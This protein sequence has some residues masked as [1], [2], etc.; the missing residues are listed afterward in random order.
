MGFPDFD[1]TDNFSELQALSFRPR[2]SLTGSHFETSNLAWK[3]SPFLYADIPHF[4]ILYR[5]CIFL[6]KLMICVNPALNKSVAWNSYF[7]SC[8]PL[9]ELRNYVKLTVFSSLRYSLSVN[10][11][12]L[13][14]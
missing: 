7:C 10:R 13:I 4:G 11:Q 2:Y 8:H 6:K 3:F 12:F 9:P 5:Y 1:Q 14:F